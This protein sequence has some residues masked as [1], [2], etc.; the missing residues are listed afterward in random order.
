MPTQPL[1]AL[2]T[3]D[4]ENVYIS[5]A[6]ALRYDSVPEGVAERGL[7]FRTVALALATP[8][9]LPTI[10]SGRLPPKHGVTWFQQTIRKEVDTIFAIPSLNVTYSELEWP[11]S[12]LHRVLGGP[13]DMALRSI[14]EPF[15]V[16]EHDNGGTPRTRIWTPPH[17]TRCWRTSI[18]APNSESITEPRWPGVRNVSTRGS[19]YWLTEDVSI[20]P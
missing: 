5:L 16:L 10:V 8:Q 14:E 11:G 9:C 17:P 13:D 12:A 19:K 6:D 18:R 15:I 4:V 20:I 3:D 1:S 2:E 7:R